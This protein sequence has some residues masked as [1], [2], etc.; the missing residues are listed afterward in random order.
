MKKNSQLH[1]VIETH[2]LNRLKEEAKEQGVSLAE[3]CR[4]K[5]KPRPQMDRIEGKLDKLLGNGIK[6]KLKR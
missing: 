3:L 4:Q 6:E 5:L 2:K 1:V